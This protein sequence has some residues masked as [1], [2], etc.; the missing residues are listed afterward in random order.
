MDE[1]VGDDNPDDNLTRGQYQGTWSDLL[2]ADNSLH[3]TYGLADYEEE[4]DDDSQWEEGH[5]R[6]STDSP[7]NDIYELYDSFDHPFRS[8][9]MNTRGSQKGLPGYFAANDFFD[10]RSAQDVDI[11]ADSRVDRYYTYAMM[12]SPSTS[13]YLVDSVA[14]ETI[15]DEAE[16]W[17]Y[18]FDITSEGQL[19]DPLANTTGEVD[20]RYGKECYLLLLDGSTAR[21]AP[22]SER[23]PE[24][25]PTGGA[26]VSLYGMG[27]RVHQLTNRKATT[28]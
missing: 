6:W 7:D 19:I 16:P 1:H 12:Y 21:V 4:Q 20:F 13:V 18:D 10:S 8:S 22:W 28:D 2:W 14:G 9:F 27:Y 5:L 25:N 24:E 26:D 3:T 11:S 23:G 17:A 15:G